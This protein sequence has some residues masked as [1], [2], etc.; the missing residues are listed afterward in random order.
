MAGSEWRVRV[1]GLARLCGPGGQQVRLERRT[2]ALLAWL[3]LQG[4]SPKFPLAALLWPDSP[5]TTVR[6]NLRQ[7]LRRLR[8]ATGDE[9][10]VEGDTERLSLVSPSAV[11]AACLKAAA[12]A[13]AP[14]EAL[15]AVG[16]EGSTL[17]AGLDFD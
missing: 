17:L 16:A 15:E 12:G 5:P 14:A 11:D 9:A 2:A 7:L 8:L 3:A 4:P 1:L 6:S 10:L 13:R